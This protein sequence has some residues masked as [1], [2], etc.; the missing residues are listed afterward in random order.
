MT[1][2]ADNVTELE[3][4]LR[5]RTPGVAAVRIE[6]FGERRAVVV[7]IDDTHRRGAL[8]PIDGENIAEA[9]RTALRK[10]L[11]MVMFVASSGADAHEGVEALHG[12]GG[13]ARELVQASGVV[14]VLAIVDGPAVSG[15][16]LLIGLADVV[17]MT[18]DAY[19]FVSSPQGVR[20]MTGVHIDIDDLGGSSTHHRTTGVAH[21]VVADTA[22][23]EVLVESLLEFLPDYTD[24]LPP[25]IDTDDPTAR[26][27]DSARDLL[28]DS[29]TG[30]YDVR[31][32]AAEIVDDGHVLELRAAW[33]PNMVTALA[34]IGG[35]PV[36]IV[37]NQPLAIAGTLDIAASQKGARFVA[38]C[39]AFNIPLLTL[40]DTPGFYPGKDLEWRG[41][42]RHGAQMAFAYARASVPRVALVLRKS[43]GGAFIVMDSKTMGNDVF[44]AWPSAEIAV[45]GARQAAEI[46]ARR[47]DEAG[48]D[49]FVA[50]YE[51]RYL[52]PYV[53][54]ERGLID[55]VIEPDETRAKLHEAFDMLRTKRDIVPSRRHDNTPL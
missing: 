19:A 42:I 25:I 24:D 53:A 22:A 41:M 31:Q 32:L 34:S 30:A 46:L 44:M 8:R 26:P 15:S 1:D 47:E 45:M 18:T 38:F 49:A 33:A 55:M 27:S 50:D 43:Y 29:P 21:E 23:A 11:P 48:K 6:R 14:P 51:E 17:I 36:G 28:P 9:A 7:R 37:A 10:R 40:V 4:E 3:L 5:S 54:A 52:N 2:V 20:Q 12:W 13:A 35:H 39:D 16:A